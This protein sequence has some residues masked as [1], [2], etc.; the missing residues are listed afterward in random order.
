MLTPKQERFW[1]EYLATGNASEAYRRAYHTARMTERTIQKRA[2]E[3]LAHVAIAGRIAAARE[4]AEDQS[5]YTL[6]QHM[7]ELKTLRELAKRNGQISAAVAAEVKRGELMGYY[8]QRRE[9][10][11]VVYTITD[12]PLTA[13]EWTAKYCLGPAAEQKH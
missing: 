13:E 11:N 2:S 4:K 5:V 10:S 6:Q 3:L 7:D 1:I 9:N 8:V 12:K